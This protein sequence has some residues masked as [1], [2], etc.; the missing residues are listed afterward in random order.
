MDELKG[1]LTKKDLTNAE[2]MPFIMSLSTLSGK[3]Y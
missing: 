1:N 3:K 2:E